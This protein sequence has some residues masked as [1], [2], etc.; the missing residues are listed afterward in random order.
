MAFVVARGLA[1]K[2]SW[3]FVRRR[4]RLLEHVVVGLREGAHNVIGT[5][6][7]KSRF[8][9]DRDSS[10]RGSLVV[11]PGTFQETVVDLPANPAVRLTN[12]AQEGT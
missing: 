3:L 5:S 8:R 2:E 4:L 7:W 6:K 11:S 12:G 1:G 10:G 9:S